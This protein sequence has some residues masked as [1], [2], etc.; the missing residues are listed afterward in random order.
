M[1]GLQGAGKTTLV[2]VIA[3][4]PSRLYCVV[5]RARAT[6]L[7]STTVKV[8]RARCT[9]FVGGRVQRGD[10]SHCRFQHAQGEQRQR[11]DQVLGPR[12]PTAFPWHVGALL[13]RGQRNCVR[14]DFPG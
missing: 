1:L 3:V 6:I 2:N 10:D 14:A 5:R 9:S 12:R 11:Y 4:R 7:F 8:M 13:S